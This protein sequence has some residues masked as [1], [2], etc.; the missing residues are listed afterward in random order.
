MGLGATILN[1]LG[2]SAV[3][4]LAEFVNERWPSETDKAA[5]LLEASKLDLEKVKED[6]LQT[7]R[8]LTVANEAEKEFNERTV[9]LEGTAIDVK[10]VWLIGPFILLLRGMQRPVWG[11]ATMWMDFRVMSGSWDVML[12][13]KNDGGNNFITPEGFILIIINFLVLAFLFG[14]RALVNILPVLNPI[15]EKIWGTKTETK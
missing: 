3:K 12:W 11:F 10:S 15:I 8:V 7:I 1:A 4:T 6:N 14:E 5:A 13:Q 2:G 9:A